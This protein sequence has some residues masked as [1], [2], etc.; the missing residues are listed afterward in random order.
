VSVDRTRRRG[1][2]RSFLVGGVVGAAAGVLAGP[3][4]RR[5]R[6]RPDGRR[7]AGLEAF[8]GAPCWHYDR[9]K[10]DTADQ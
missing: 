3:R 2:L 6:P 9:G 1:V 8:E 5:G 7:V 10:D 4:L